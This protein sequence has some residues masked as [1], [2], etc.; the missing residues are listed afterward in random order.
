MDV[1]V[2][3]MRVR[4]SH[5]KASSQPVLEDESECFFVV[6]IDEMVEKALPT[7]LNKD[8]MGTYLPIRI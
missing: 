1:S 5:F 2:M 4:L 3:N 7:I 8:S 6:V